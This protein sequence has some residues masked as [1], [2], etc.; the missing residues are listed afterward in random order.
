MGNCFAKTKV[1]PT[2][3]EPP[4]QTP[5]DTHVQTW[6]LRMCK[7]LTRGGSKHQFCPP[8]PVDIL[9]KDYKK[10]IHTFLSTMPYHLT[11]DFC[12]LH[13]RIHEEFHAMNANKMYTN[14]FESIYDDV[15]DTLIDLYE[16]NNLL[17]DPELRETEQIKKMFN[18]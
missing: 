1:S 16:N 9:L 12:K 7:A 17:I 13:R 11:K 2:D 8:L 15:V 5:V 10:L 14:E 3:P 4:I 18:L 6:C